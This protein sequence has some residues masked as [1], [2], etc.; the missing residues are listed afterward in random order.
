MDGNFPFARGRASAVCKPEFLKKVAALKPIDWLPKVQKVRLRDA[1]FEPNTPRIAKDKL[2]AAV[3]AGATVV[4]YNPEDFN[5]VVRD[6]K[7]LEW[8]ERELESLPAG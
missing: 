5:A 1:L 2:R 6:K 4:I 7:E 3:P 8:I